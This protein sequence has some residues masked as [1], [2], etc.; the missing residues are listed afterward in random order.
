MVRSLSTLAR[1]ERLTTLEASA[2]TPQ[3]A[4]YF[5]DRNHMPLK[6]FSY[7]HAHENSLWS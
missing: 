3:A 5:A 2:V 7:G 1:D 4:Y 6:V